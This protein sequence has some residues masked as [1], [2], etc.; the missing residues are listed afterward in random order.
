MWIPLLLLPV[1]RAAR[2]DWKRHLPD[3]IFVP[4]GFCAPI[5]A[6]C[7][8]GDAVAPQRPLWLVLLL[9][10]AIPYASWN[11][12]AAATVYLNHTHPELPWFRDERTW[13]SYNGNVLGTVHVKMPID[14][15][16][17]Y[18][19]VMTHVAHH[20]NVRTPVYALPDEQKELKA[21]FV[22]NVKAYTLPL[23]A[24]PPSLSAPY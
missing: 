1:S 2:A 8:L 17:L 7:F 9:G 21:R 18:T 4:A 12:L 13:N 16:P 6:L 10:W 20:T 24:Y 3:S 22:P 19:D 23:A 15:F 5:A 11:Y 14:I